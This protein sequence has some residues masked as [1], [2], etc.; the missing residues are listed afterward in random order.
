MTEESYGVLIEKNMIR[1]F[2]IIILQ[3]SYEILFF[4]RQNRILPQAKKL[5]QYHFKARFTADSMSL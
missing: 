3:L 1:V 5:C 2:S 4:H